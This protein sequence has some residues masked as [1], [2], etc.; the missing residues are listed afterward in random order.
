MRRCLCLIAPFAVVMAAQGDD[1][2]I[3]KNITVGGYNN[4][5]IESSIKGARERDVNNNQVTLRQCDLKRTVTINDQTQT[6]FIANDPVEEKPTAGASADSGG[7]IVITTTVTDIGE[8]K[9]FR[10]YPVRHL[11]MTVVQEPTKD[12]CTKTTQKFEIDGWYTDLS[13]E[14]ISCSISGPPV[15]QDQGCNDKVVQRR[16]GSARP[17]YPLD[18]TVIFH[19][20]DGTTTKLGVT[21]T[22]ISKQTLE[23]ELFDIPAGYQQ[24]N[25]LAELNGGP[26]APTQAQ[27]QSP[28]GAGQMQS[29]NRGGNTQAVMQ[30]AMGGANPAAQAATWNQQP[31]MTQ[32]MNMPPAGPMQPTGANPMA[33]MGGAAMAQMGGAAM[34]QRGGNPMAMMQQM[35]GGGGMPGMAQQ[36]PGPA[37]AQVAAPQALGPKTP[38]KIRIGVAPPDAQL[39]Q[40]SNTGQDYSTPIRNSMVLLMSGPAVE[41][42]ALDSHIPMQLQAEAQ[43]KQCDFVMFSAVSVKHGQGG[44]FGK[45]MKMGSMAASMTPMGAMG[46]GMGGAVAAQ[47]ASAAA[48]AAAMSAQQQAMNQLAG[49]NHEIKSKDDVTVQ[50][51]LVQTGQATPR[52][53]NQLQG[54][55]K[56][57]GEDVLTPLL[58]QTANS[59]LTEATKK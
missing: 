41:I 6:Y 26:V 44:G 8:R 17:G 23:P 15:R 49:F 46:R 51:S 50:Y 28:T 12:A 48:S 52:I 53:Q 54:K 43:Q 11:K 56:S 1:L 27:M 13:K 10:G 58:Q 37:A 25:S 38:G 24:V 3:K 5:T 42:A 39:G 40:G 57:D 9:Q 36:Q 4:S 30:Q 45:F 29:P 19:N 59:V 21:A 35:M 16:T 14:Q 22:D 2:H 7:K 47:A 31:Q 55:A 20:A 18:E 32:S 33:Q 34:G